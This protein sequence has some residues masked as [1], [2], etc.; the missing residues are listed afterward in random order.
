MFFLVGLTAFTGCAT[1]KL[2]Q[3]AAEPKCVLEKN[4]IAC[5]E[6]DGY[7]LLPV[8]MDVI[9][10]VVA[11]AFNPAALVTTLESQGV[12]D[13]PCVLAAL[14]QYV[15]PTNQALGVKFHEVLKASL[16]R[17][18]MHGDVVVKLKTGATVH[19]VVP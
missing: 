12:K 5:G 4:L 3:N 16:A 1:C 19:A 10:S 6:Q 13:V 14:E 2:P 8:V 18:G 11:G 9:G 15:A 7:S 17:R